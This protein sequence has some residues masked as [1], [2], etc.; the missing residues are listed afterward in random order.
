MKKRLTGFIHDKFIIFTKPK[1]ATSFLHTQLEIK[2][3]GFRFDIEFNDTFLKDYTI[4]WGG[5]S[6]GD[7]RLESLDIIK[8]EIDKIYEGKSK[9]DI[10]FLYREVKSRFY[11][12]F[13]QDN[14]SG[15]HLYQWLTL[16]TP[17]GRIPNEYFKQ[18]LINKFSAEE[19]N[20]FFD[21]LTDSKNL[22][23]FEDKSTLVDFLKKDTSNLKMFEGLVEEILEMYVNK[24]RDFKTAHNESYLF[25]YYILYNTFDKNKCKFIKLND[26]NEVL[27][28]NLETNFTLHIKENPTPSL[29][30]SIVQKIFDSKLENLVLFESLFSDDLH[31]YDIFENIRENN[32][33]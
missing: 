6:G 5:D 15:D 29:L 21:Y 31:L 33:K 27:N 18:Y 26:L 20:S 30:T 23:R 16:N 11:S 10:Y 28:K 32:L 14:L 12:A 8:K 19:V 13:V 7:S 1:I 9:L 2:H 22:A 4:R 24:I 3:G 25:L 17:L